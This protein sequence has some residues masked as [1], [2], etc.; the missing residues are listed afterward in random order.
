MNR[1]HPERHDRGW[2]AVLALA[3]LV[4]AL[5]A[6][7]D[8]DAHRADAKHAAGPLALGH[9][10]DTADDEVGTQPATVVAERGDR[11]IRRDEQRQ[12]VE[13]LRP[14]EADQARTL[15]GDGDDVRRD[16]GTAPG[17]A[18]HEGFAVRAERAP[19][20]EE[21]RM[22]ARGED[23]LVCILHVHDPI[24]VD[25]QWADACPFQE[26]AAHGLHRVSPDLGDLHRSGGLA[27]PRAERPPAD[28]WPS[29]PPRGARP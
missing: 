1:T 21:A 6:L 11:A 17:P 25:A 24:S 15:S 28:P 9:P 23:P 10:R 5:T 2:L 7:L 19:V 20:S 18:V 12:D 29:R 3:L 27:G 22:A 26:L 14:V 8:P 4:A 13:S 16:L